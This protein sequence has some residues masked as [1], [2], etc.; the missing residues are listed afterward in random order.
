MYLD[1][2]NL[3]FDSDGCPV[4]KIKQGHALFH[5]LLAAYLIHDFV[6]AHDRDP[7]GPCLG[8]ASEIARIALTKAR[9]VH[10]SL[11][12]FYDEVD[13]LSYV[14]GRFYSALTQAWFIAS[15]CE[16]RRYRRDFDESI[17]LIF[18]SLLVPI[19]EGGVLVKKPFGWIVEEYPHQPRFYTLNGW[20]TVLQF[21]I[22]H[23]ESLS[24]LGLDPHEF[25][26]HN[27]QAAAHLMPLYDAG[28]CLNSRYQ[29]T[30]F[31]RIQ[32]IFDR[33]VKV[34]LNEFA[35]QIPGEGQYPGKLTKQKSRW[36][37]YVER[38]EGRLIQFNVVLSLI[39]FPERNYF[40]VSLRTVEPCSVT[41]RLAKGEYSPQSTGM[42]TQR[43]EDVAM[44]DLASS[45]EH[46][47]SCTIPYDRQNLFAYPTNFKKF[48]NGKFHN[49]YHFTHIIG[50]A[51]LYRYTGEPIFKDYC[52]R[53]LGY[54]EQW[55]NLGLPDSYSLGRHVPR[56][57]NFL[58]DIR[59]LLEGVDKGRA[60]KPWGTRLE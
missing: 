27:I 47:I 43:W 15:L 51:E 2:Y 58:A 34:E 44:F 10:E 50:C 8:F 39:G 3:D 59:R 11:A 21:L 1:Y 17:I 42:P 56:S 7:Q 16:L 36:T 60:V 40:S 4:K 14:P 35:V 30:G 6:M 46:S 52:E 26:R 23:A 22:R 38:S 13:G 28:F 24:E 31:S 20:L 5:P 49:A 29:L 48:I 25:L 9:P 55:A 53:F 54:V 33:E 18:R 19:D 37:N 57:E 41:V 45:G 12:F 32:L